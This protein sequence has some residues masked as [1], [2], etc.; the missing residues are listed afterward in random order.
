VWI[1]APAIANRNR[2]DVPGQTQAARLIYGASDRNEIVPIP[3]RAGETPYLTACSF[4]QIPD[5][6]ERRAA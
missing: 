4:K 1:A 3:A 6:I 2:I 5:D